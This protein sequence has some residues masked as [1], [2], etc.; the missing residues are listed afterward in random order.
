MKPWH[1]F[2]PIRMKISFLEKGCYSHLFFSGDD[3]ACRD[4][5]TVGRNYF[6]KE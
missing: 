5:G 4:Y 3:L 2:D 1:L 6:G